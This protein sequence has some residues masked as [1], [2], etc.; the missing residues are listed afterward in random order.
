MSI[1][2]INQQ[3]VENGEQYKKKDIIK[4]E[5]TEVKRQLR[6]GAEPLLR[7]GSCV[8]CES[9]CLVVGGRVECR[10]SQEGNYNCLPCCLHFF[11]QHNIYD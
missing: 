6:N 8:T 4:Q 3:E 7:N 11:A 5:I 1:R 9:V 10:C 2:Q